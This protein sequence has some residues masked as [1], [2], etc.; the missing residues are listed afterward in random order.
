MPKQRVKVRFHE[1][2]PERMEPGDLFFISHHGGPATCRFWS[3]CDDR[4]LHVVLP[5]GHLWD[6]DGRASNCAVREDLAH[7]CWV[8]HGDPRTGDIHVDKEGVTCAAGAGSIVSSG[9]HGFLH[10][11]E[12]VEI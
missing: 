5:N 1:Q 2:M 8:R 9:Y 10:H 3:N 4:H 12:L 7:R 11:G 6:I